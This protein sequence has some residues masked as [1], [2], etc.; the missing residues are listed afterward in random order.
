MIQSIAL[1]TSDSVEQSKSLI[2]YLSDSMVARVKLVVRCQAGDASV[3]E[4]SPSPQVT[5]ACLDTQSQSF[6]LNMLELLEQQQIY[7][8]VV[9]N[10][11]IPLPE[12]TLQLLKGRVINLIP[13]L[14]LNRATELMFGPAKP[15]RVRIIEPDVYNNR[16]GITGYLVGD[17]F[18]E[19][20][21]MRQESCP[22]FPDDT[23]EN[24]QERIK[25]LA[26]CHYPI[27]IERACRLYAKTEE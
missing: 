26:Y 12:G 5:V 9:N 23:A 27:I 15:Q 10:L 8:V 20:E 1:F 14:Q 19:G 4:K 11:H 7:W 17:H 21:I 3:P 2:H 24:I 18:N 25:M 6:K 16:A 13:S 22:V